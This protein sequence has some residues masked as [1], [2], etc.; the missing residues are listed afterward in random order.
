MSKAKKTLE[1]RGELV[2]RAEL[3][4]LFGV[5]K[6]TVD[7]WVRR[8]CPIRARGGSGIRSQFDT[9]EVFEWCMYRDPRF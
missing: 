4:K 2:T 9:A 1:P 8:G 3:A 6:T 7:A 5:A